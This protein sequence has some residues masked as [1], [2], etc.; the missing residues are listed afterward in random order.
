MRALPSYLLWALIALLALA[1]LPLLTVVFV[2]TAPFDPGRYRA[3]RWFRRA[4]VSAVKLVP[5]WDFRTEG[6]VVDDPRRPYIAVSNHE[7]YADIFLLSHLPWEMKWLSKEEIFRI[8][9]MGWM[10]RMAGD[11]AV[12]RGDRA[13]RAGATAQIRD[14]LDK[15]VSVMILP[16]GTRSPSGELLPFRD[17]AFRIAIEK[18]VPVLPVAV[19]GTRE[20]MAKHSMRFNRARAVA[21]V[22]EPVPTEGL[23]ARDIAKLRDDVRERIRVARDELRQELGENGGGQAPTGSGTGMVK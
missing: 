9:V 21:R 13:S 1:W 17:G 7:S 4:A 10:M 5:I 8:P 14:R 18:Q 22:L 6:V 2:L 20:A 23:R 11:I 16:E 15:N 19:A 12:R 3:G